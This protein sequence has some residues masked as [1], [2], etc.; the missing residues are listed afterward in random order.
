[1][2]YYLRTNICECC[3]RYDE[4]HIGKKS[5]GWEFM[6]R[7]YLSCD[8]FEI[9]S[10]D[11]WRMHILRSGGQIFDEEHRTISYYDFIDMVEKSK[12]KYRPWMPDGQPAA[13]ERIPQ[14]HYEYCLK[15]NLITTADWLDK[16]GWSFYA[17]E[18]S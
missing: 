9:R 17:G 15:H 6:F 12:E 2:N 4:Y 18:F 1:M 13:E 11:E 7:G 5:F 16:D 14:S 10:W 8:A 3:N